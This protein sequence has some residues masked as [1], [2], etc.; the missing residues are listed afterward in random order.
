MVRADVARTRMLLD[1]FLHF[2]RQLSQTRL[3]S[4]IIST[5]IDIRLLQLSRIIPLSPGDF[6]TYARAFHSASLHR[7]GLLASV[8][9]PISST[10]S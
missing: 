2:V 6:F 8:P 3:L 1:R 7:R 9:L 4:A 10:I 5:L